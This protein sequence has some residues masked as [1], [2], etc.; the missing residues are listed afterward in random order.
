VLGLA[1]QILLQNLAPSFAGIRNTI[2]GN[3]TGSAQGVTVG[4]TI[5]AGWPQDGLS[6]GS[7]G[8]D[9]VAPAV[10]ADGAGGALI[11][12]QE[13]QGG[14]FK[15][16]LLRVTGNGTIAAGWASA[17]VVP[18]SSARHQL[19]P[20]LTSDLANGALMAWEES[21]A[22]EHKLLVARVNGQGTLQS[23]WPSTGLALASAAGQQRLA[24]MTG[25]G[26]GGALVA[27][28]DT[29]SGSGDIYA[30]RFTAS[31]AIG[32][33]W[34]AAGLAACSQGSEQYA[35]AILADGA[36]GAFIVWEDFRG[37]TTDVYAQRVTGGGAISSG[38]PTDGVA[39]TTASGEQYAPRLM[40][41]GAG[42]AIA[43]WFDTRTLNGPPVLVPETPPRPLV[44]A[45]Y[46][47]RPSPAVG[48]LRIAFDLPDAKPAKL[49]LLDVAGRR[50]M[51]R[52]V[53]S[54]GPGRHVVPIDERKLRAGIYVVR[55]T[56]AGRSLTA[57]VSVLR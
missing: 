26:A 49:E 21:V 1:N 11:A 55:L 43:T 8:V 29:R 5:A 22:G 35:P 30:Q 6:I 17:G 10:V 57:T 4:G 50:I 45:L 25:D 42:G 16:R 46:G 41:D 47:A 9:Q 20:V 40:S 37:G 32:S 24:A 13:F 27:W 31:G 54:L 53:G 36:S 19:T 44:F 34:P 3:S 18:C 7:A 12:W 2:L 56:H 23:G 52:E 28:Y 15:V 48:D 51:S 33:G 38:W 14:L 39:L